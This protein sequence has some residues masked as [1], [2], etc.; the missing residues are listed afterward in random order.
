MLNVAIVVL[1][2]AVGWRSLCLV[3]RSE[4]PLIF[5]ISGSEDTGYSKG[6][7][8]FIDNRYPVQ[9]GDGVLIIIPEREGTVVGKVLEDKDDRLEVRVNRLIR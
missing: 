4:Q 1:M 5:T 7:L 3:S 2:I 8:L 9:V 6:D